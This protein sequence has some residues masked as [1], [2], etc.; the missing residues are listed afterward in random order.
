[1]IFLTCPVFYSRLCLLHNLLVF[2]L[3]SFDQLHTCLL[4]TL[5][6]FRLNFFKDMHFSQLLI[7]I[8]YFTP[9]TG[10]EDKIQDEAAQLRQII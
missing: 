1:M 8:A 6:F 9:E 7:A 3:F 4:L 5:N 2:G 10:Q